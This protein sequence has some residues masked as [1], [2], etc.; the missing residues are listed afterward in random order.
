M[1]AWV[2]VWRWPTHRWAA[3][4]GKS[5][6]SKRCQTRLQD[7]T[8]AAAAGSN[9]S[10]P[11]HRA[12][13]PSAIFHGT[14][15]TMTYCAPSP[16]APMPPTDAL[17]ITS[18]PLEHLQRFSVSTFELTLLWSERPLQ[19]PLRIY[20]DG[21]RESP[22]ARPGVTWVNL[23]AAQPWA[24]AVLTRAKSTSALRQ[25]Y[26]QGRLQCVVPMGTR[27]CRD[28][29]TVLKVAALFD[30][31]QRVPTPS[32]LLWL[33]IDCFFQRPLDLACTHTTL[34]SRHARMQSRPH[35]RACSRASN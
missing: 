16:V 7:R 35:P 31:V 2:L 30:A 17:A 33:D 25:A 18:T 26:S 6:W 3:R 11:R 34:S 8:A 27:L 19:L 29:F 13:D 1:P 9:V 5:I 15:G 28:I 22:P 10:R 21:S 32:A 4:M 12:S 24:Y 14:D 20:Y 23:T